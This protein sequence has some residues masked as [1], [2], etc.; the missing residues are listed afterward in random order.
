MV[1]G[2]AALILDKHPDASP[3]E[4]K[5]LLTSTAAEISGKSQA[6]GGGEL[7]LATT[8]IGARAELDPDVAL[9]GRFGQARAVARHRSP[10]ARR[11]RAERRAGHL[12]SALRLGRDGGPRGERQQLVGCQVE[13]ELLVRQQLV[14]QLAWSGSSVV[15]RQVVRQQLVAAARGRASSGPAAAGAATPGPATAGRRRAGTS[16]NPSGPAGPHRSPYTPAMTREPSTGHARTLRIGITG[17]IGCGKST[18]AGW[19]G[20]RPGRRR[21]R[22]RRGRARGPRARRAGARRGRRAL[23]VRTCS[24]PM[25][26]L[27]R[28]ALGRVGLRRPGRAAR[29]RGDRPSGGAA[30]DPRGDGRRGGRGADAVVVEAIRLVE[31]GLAALCDEVWLVE[32]DPAVQRERLVGRGS[33][34]GRRRPADR[35]PGRADRPGRAGWPPASSIHPGRRRRRARCVEDALESAL[36]PSRDPAAG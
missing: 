28:A 10:D 25:A 12:R 5:K 7:Q 15:G 26:S 24:A 13:R 9:L 23:R 14:G 20:E 30:A 22:R 18:V 16:R 8:L 33:T 31:G 21:H 34:R 27:D 17:P 3:N 2:A 29:P 35:G 1:S 19:L 4:V 11:R 6:I 32:C 36:G